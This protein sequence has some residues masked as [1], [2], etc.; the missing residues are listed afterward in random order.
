MAEKVLHE[1]KVVETEDGYR[2]EIK[3]DKEKMREFF[4]KRGGFG[5]GRFMGGHGP[6][7]HGPWGFFGRH[8][9]G[10]GPWGWG[11]W[12]DDEEP[13]PRRGE[14]APKA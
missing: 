4:S 3:G 11:G 8:R 9:G 12:E 1:V 5:P 10:H 6:F 2:I 7:G 14:P 13:E